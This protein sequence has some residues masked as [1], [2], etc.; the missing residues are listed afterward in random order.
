MANY[1]LGGVMNAEAFVERDGKLEHYFS[2]KTLTD[3]TVNVS[4]SSEEIRGGEGAQLLGRFFHTSNFGVNLTDALFDFKY[5]E[6]QIGSDIKDDGE[7]KYFEEEVVTIA[8]GKGTLKNTPVALFDN[9]QK[10]C[11]GSIENHIAWVRDCDGNYVTVYPTKTS[12]Y[13][14]FATELA[15]G[16]YC[17]KYPMSKDGCR[18]VVINAMYQ[19]KEFKLILTGNLF[20]GSSCSIA[21]SSKV[22]KLVIE[23]PRFQLDGTIDLGLN[24]SSA[25][26]IALNGNA[27]AYGCG[28]NSQPQ[29]AKMTEILEADQYEAYT[30]IAVL[31]KEDLHVGDRVYVYATGA[32]KMPRRFLGAYTVKYT[33]SNTQKDALDANGLIVEGALTKALTI[34]VTEEGA[35]KG[36]TV[37]TGVVKAKA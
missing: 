29:Y 37:T 33:D 20:A 2:A 4:V 14:E 36:E 18:Q 27:L 19:P 8:G 22:G 34:A 3:S 28:C 12:V 5:L 24:M 16:D 25:A 6:A 9:D 15:D 10:V 7:G 26:T 32:K 1:I 31:N 17:V 13:K 23:I 30:S 21:N 35:L 11:A